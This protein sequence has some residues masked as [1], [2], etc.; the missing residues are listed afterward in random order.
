MRPAGM[1]PDRT[2]RAHGTSRF[3]V[4]GAVAEPAAAACL[5]DVGEQ[6]G[7]FIAGDAGEAQGTNSR[8]VDE[9]CAPAEV[10]ER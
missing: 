7:K 1:A 5:V 10:I 6:D 9:G 8:R 3:V 4:V 2:A